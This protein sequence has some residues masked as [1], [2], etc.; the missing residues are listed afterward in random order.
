MSEQQEET[1]IPSGV[2]STQEKEPE[3]TQSTEEVVQSK[4][5]SEEVAASEEQAS[6]TESES[7]GENAQTKEGRLVFHSAGS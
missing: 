4:P 7:M 3:P 1:Q 6:K 2:D 5:D